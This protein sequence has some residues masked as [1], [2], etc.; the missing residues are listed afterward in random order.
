MEELSVERRG[1]LIERWAHALVRRGYGAAA[2]FIL[3]GHKPLAPLGAQ[4]A[5]LIEPYAFGRGRGTVREFAS[6]LDQP[7]NVEALLRRIE[8]LDE[9]ARTAAAAAKA[10]RKEARRRARRWRLLRTERVLTPPPGTSA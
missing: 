10:R 8:E 9:A 5:L 7:E 4:L 3:E 1:E 6:F 2:L